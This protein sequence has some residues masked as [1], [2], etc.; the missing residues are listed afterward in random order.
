L[1][2]LV[3]LILLGSVADATPRARPFVAPGVRSS[4]H[5]DERAID[6]WRAL[7][8]RDTGVPAWLW[9]RPVDAPGSVADPARAEAVARAFLAAHPALAPGARASDFAIITNERDG[10]VRSVGMRQS[11]RGLPVIGGQIG[12]VFAHD[13]LFAVTSHALPNVA[14]PPAHGHAVLPLVRAGSVDYRIV[15]VI[16]AG[17]WDIY[18]DE[19]G[20]EVARARKYV[21]AT[22]T[23][24]YDAGVRYASGPR[25]AFPA[26]AANITVNAS[27]ATTG[28]DGTF[29]WTGSSPA[30]VA[31]GVVGT[32]VQIID[33]Q[34]PLAT[35]SLSAS[36][37]TPTPWSLA[38]DEIGD[39]QLSTYV[40]ANLAKARARI[41]NPAVATWLDS[42]WPFSVN[43]AGEC[44]AYTTPSGLHFYRASSQC[45]NTGRVADIVFHEFGHAL[46]YQSVLNGVGSFVPEL[47]EGLADYF[48]ANLTEDHAVGRGLYY[49]DTP[50][51]DIAPYGLE[52]R[53]PD[54]I[55]YDIHI[56]GEIVSGALWDLR[57]RFIAEFGHD[58]GVAL[59]EKI[60]TGVMQRATDIP[61]SY[62]AALV[63]DDDD[64]NLA[65]GTPHYCDI[66]RA[67]G[68][69]G[70]AGSDYQP[71]VV[72]S[73]VVD[74][75]AMTVT[76]ATPTAGACPIAH[77]TGI[78]VLWQ[79]DNGVPG[80]FP[81][82]AQ[83]DTWTGS[84]PTLADGTVISYLI[85]A[86]LDDGSHIVL[87]DNP[88][89]PMYETFVGFARQIWCEHFDSGDPQWTQ[90]GNQGDAWQVGTPS[91]ST[92]SHDPP[93]A[94][95]G[96]DAYGTYL[97]GSGEYHPDEVTSTSTPVIDVSS[98][99]LVHLQYFRWLAVED[100]TYDQATIELNGT[101]VWGNARD[102]TGTLDHIDK[103]WR[104][105]DLDAT[106][107]IGD[108]GTLQATWTLASDATKQ[109]GGW[110]I[111]DVCFVGLDK[112]AVCGDGIVDPGEQ[113]DDG[114]TIA[115]DGCSP[116]CRNEIVASGGGCSA[117][118]GAG[119]LIAVAAAALTFCRD[120]AR[121][122]RS[123]RACR[124]KP[125]DHADRR[126]S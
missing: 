48:A 86:A 61:S 31:P 88:A 119:W 32:Y 84:F 104:F 29:S 11:W 102:K 30:T 73:P 121:R 114:N 65:N 40:Y 9:G 1:R 46:H 7:V 24:T 59:A 26:V 76:V 93:T 51:R 8:D 91:A 28:A 5:L 78:S 110:T 10:D 23:L 122:D 64:G 70:L 42:A 113:C 112:I 89:D 107:M 13:R 50:V 63:A 108:A 34:N 66:Q 16:D 17:E 106:M 124:S 57:T 95:S 22:S 100:S 92:I 12:F 126:R 68:A 53:Y 101:R 55:N 18:R 120:R 87:P 58:A 111:D 90:T 125:E 49:D 82:S 43:E 6:G 21:D 109:L 98:Y 118:G 36:D 83:G 54:D 56:T 62:M 41:V 67:F 45:Q 117:G 69:H 33:N 97:T 14:P 81:L 75:L 15:D 96:A 94:H 116:T 19:H 47:S 20:T 3:I 99:Q 52:M 2:A 71:T 77:V 37:G 79:V 4:R 80:N 105:H 103:E 25:A 44:N 38:S 74:Q 115:G 39:A 60:F 72:G 85:D 123:R 35:A 27:A